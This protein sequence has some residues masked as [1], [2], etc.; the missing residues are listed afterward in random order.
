MGIHKGGISVSE[1]LIHE[2]RTAFTRLRVVDKKGWRYL[3]FDDDSGDERLKKT[4]AVYQS[5]IRLADPVRSWDSYTLA[6]QIPFLVA[7]IAR[8]FFVGLGGGTIMHQYLHCY[9]DMHLEVAEIDPEVIQIART[10]FAL[11]KAL[12]V[13]RGDGRK[14]LD[15]SPGNYDLIALDAF[16]ARTMPAHLLTVEFFRLVKGKL[17]EGGVVALNVNAALEGPPGRWY[18][19]IGATLKEVFPYLLAFPTL[20]QWPHRY[21]MILMLA[22]S[23]PFPSKQGIM[24][25][26]RQRQEHYALPLRFLELTQDPQTYV[27]ERVHP[28][29]DREAEKRPQL[30][31][32]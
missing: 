6:F 10:Y 4:E 7:C 15:S 26:A 3:V 2:G 20:G 21:Q 9:G 14:L 23:K 18:H 30:P 29:T 8:T 12:K 31:I 19:R 22:G 28:I 16:W 32:Y 24:E 25:R 1:V 17:N 27:S 13:H 5:R 11:P